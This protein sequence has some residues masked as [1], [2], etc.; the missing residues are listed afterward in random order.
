M[1]GLYVTQSS[2][3]NQSLISLPNFYVALPNFWTW[4]LQI[5][6]TKEPLVEEYSVAAQVWKLTATDLCEIARNSVV[7]SGFPHQVDNSFSILFYCTRALP[8]DHHDKSC[9]R[10][11][12]SSNNQKLSTPHLFGI[13]LQRIQRCLS[14]TGLWAQVKMHWVHQTYWKGGPDG[15]DIH[16]TNVPNLRMRFRYDALITEQGLVFDGAESHRLRHNQ[17]H[18]Q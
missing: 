1:R 3:K 8:S 10:L 4:L 14:D 15:N 16:K 13:S 2:S 11:R 9:P 7:H 5:H 6:L 17:K 12:I 18:H